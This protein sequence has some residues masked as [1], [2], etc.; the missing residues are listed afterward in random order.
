[1]FIAK[2]LRFVLARYVLVTEEGSRIQKL[3]GQWRMQLFINGKMRKHCRLATHDE[4]SFWAGFERGG[5]LCSLA[6]ILANDTE[7]VEGI[8]IYPLQSIPRI[9]D[10]NWKWIF[11][12]EVIDY[13][14][15]YSPK[16][17][18]RVRQRE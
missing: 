1:L 17:A 15:D 2:I 13:I 7:V 4:A 11:G 12:R 18:I 5:I 3:A 10:R 16:L 9:V 6:W 14:Q 8:K